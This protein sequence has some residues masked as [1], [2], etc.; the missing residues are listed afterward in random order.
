MGGAQLSETDDLVM[1]RRLS[2]TYAD[3][4]D[5]RD[6]SALARLFGH[7]GRLILPALGGSGGDTLTGDQVRAALDPLAVYDRTF[8]HV[9]G[10]VF[11][12][13]GDRASGRVQCSA[14]HYERTH[15]GPIDLV[16]FI[17]YDD[18]Y[19]RAGG[20]WIFDRRVVDVRWTE[21]HPANRVRR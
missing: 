9:G 10:A 13:D 5:R 7:D 21:A 20:D 3:A 17:V 11:E 16:M 8:H 18:E 12:L 1:L 19:R 14:H 15:N 4:V 6:A 2:D